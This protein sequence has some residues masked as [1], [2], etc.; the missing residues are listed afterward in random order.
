MGGFSHWWGKERGQK[1][2]G[3]TTDEWW[4]MRQGLDAKGYCLGKGQGSKLLLVVVRA[5]GGGGEGTHEKKGTQQ[6]VNCQ[7]GDQGMV[8]E[9]GTT[10][11]L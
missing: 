4:P 7:K 6:R 1:D 11:Y 2:R 8:G 3:S 10:R 9:E 5:V